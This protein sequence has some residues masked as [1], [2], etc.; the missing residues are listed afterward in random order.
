MC[1][2]VHHATWY[3]LFLNSAGA[4]R[5]LPLLCQ[6][7][8]KFPLDNRPEDFDCVEGALTCIVVDK[9][10]QV[11]GVTRRQT[12]PAYHHLAKLYLQQLVDDV[13][14][15][16]D[17]T[18]VAAKGPELRC[19]EITITTRTIF[20]D[21]QEQLLRL[22]PLSGRVMA[23]TRSIQFPLKDSCLKK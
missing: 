4:P 23:R 7:T 20:I 9:L 12:E 11:M 16:T 17:T 21:T 14:T 3:D 22:G 19:Q 8:E 5:P 15:D 6:E 10:D 1:V 2:H 18:T 13:V